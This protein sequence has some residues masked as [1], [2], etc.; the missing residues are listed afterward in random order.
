[1]SL[2]QLNKEIDESLRDSEND[3]VVNALDLKSKFERWS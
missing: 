2:E 1:M 3:R